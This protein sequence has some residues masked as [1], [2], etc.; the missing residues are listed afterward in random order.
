MSIGFLPLRTSL[1]ILVFRP[2]AAIAIIMKN[3]LKSLNGV[4]NSDGT[5]ALTAM[6]VITEAATKNKMKKGE[7]FSERNFFGRISFFFCPEKGQ[8]KSDRDN[9]QC[10][11]QFDGDC[12]VQ[13]GVSKIVDGIPCG[14]C[15][16]DRGCIIDCRSGKNSKGFPAGGG[17]SNERAKFREEEGGQN[18]KKENNGNGLSHLLI[19]SVDNR[20]RGGDSGTA[21]DGGPHTD[22]GRCFGWYIHGLVKNKGNDQRC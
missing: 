21:A 5:P 3:L 7:D 13:S 4:K 6:V 15:G 1:T 17:K 9:G 8:K 19:I 2:M 14:S 11:G 12:F 22:E 18:V 20:G 10:A 16:C